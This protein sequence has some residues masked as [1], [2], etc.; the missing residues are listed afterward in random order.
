MDGGTTWASVPGASVECNFAVVSLYGLDGITV[1]GRE[2]QLLLRQMVE[3]IGY[4]T[5]THGRWKAIR[6]LLHYSK[7]TVVFADD[8]GALSMVMVKPDRLSFGRF[9]T[10]CPLRQSIFVHTELMTKCFM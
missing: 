1:F 9:G 3:W 7:D 4:I 8:R 6:L 5:Q 2:G 10:Q